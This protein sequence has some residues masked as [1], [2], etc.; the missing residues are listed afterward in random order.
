MTFSFAN[1][2]IDSFFTNGPQMALSAAV[3]ARLSLEGLATIGDFSDFKEAQ[4]YD[5]FKNMRTSIHGV[6]A[7]QEVRD[8][9]DN[10][11]ILIHVVAAVPPVAPTLVSAKCGLRLKIASVAF[12]YYESIIRDINAQDFYTE[13]EVVIALSDETKP[14][15]HVL[16][17][18]NS[19]LKWIESFRDCLFRTYGLQKTPSLYVIRDDVAPPA[20]IED[21]LVNGKAY[22]SS[23]SII[24]E[25]IARLTHAD[26]LYKADNASV[27]SMMEEATRGT[28]YASTVKPYSR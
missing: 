24:D 9:V 4:L 7:V 21:P 11:I 19:P 26:P 25:L 20:E 27:Y 12:H 8:L 17:K 22:G 2:K 13:Y 28:I 16:S 3:R 23:G 10:N 15:V 1:N 18:N 5:A 14:S 6:P